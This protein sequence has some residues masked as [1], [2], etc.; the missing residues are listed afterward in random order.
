[1]NHLK[2][3]I[4]IITVLI[5]FPISLVS[6]TA[7]IKAYGMQVSLGVGSTS[8]GDSLYF[9][10]YDGKSSY[11]LNNSNYISSELKPLSKGSNSYVTDYLIA[12]YYGV[13]E[14]GSVTLNISNTDTDGNGVPDWLQKE[15]SV[16]Q[17]ITGN[18]YVHYQSPDSY[19]S[20]ANLSGSFTRSAGSS[21]GYYSLNY[22][23][24]GLGSATASGTWYVGFYE[25]TVEYD[26]NSVSINAT[27][28]DSEG[29]SLSA[30]SS[31]TYSINNTESVN[32]GD[33][34]F[35]LNGQTVK[36]SMGSLTRSGNS[37]SG[38]AT[39]ADGEPDTSW[40][41]Y[42][43]W[44]VVITDQNDQDNDGIPDLSDPVEESTPTPPLDLDGWNWYKWPWVYNQ[45]TKGWY[46]YHLNS[47]W[48]NSHQQWFSW[49]NSTSSWISQN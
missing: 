27:T 45:S 8:F 14:Y 38:F 6:K 49:D 30:K 41:D 20:N 13:Y 40:A 28:I 12:D 19:S 47:V 24:P 34:N 32:F 31:S 10:S 1:M 43:D 7:S 48:S 21:N 5:Y 25:G 18:S 23:I 33:V 37:Y 4:Y 36:L 22:S 29:Y 16:N 44:F 15:K 17:T 3:L 46:Y 9:T 2:L 35:D 42:I 39:A 26:Q 11:P